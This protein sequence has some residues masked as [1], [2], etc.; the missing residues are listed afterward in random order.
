MRAFVM[1]RQFTQ[2]YAELN[3][4]L[5]DFMATTDT[6]FS[7]VFQ[8]LVEQKRIAEKPR[9]RVGF[10]QNSEKTSKIS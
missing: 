10:V 7:E 4:K 9:T 1:M 5:N 6:Q 2:D 8:I 3:R